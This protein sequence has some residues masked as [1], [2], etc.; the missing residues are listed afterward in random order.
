MPPHLSRLSGSPRYRGPLLLIGLIAAAALLPRLLAL[1]GI[2]HTWHFDFG[3]GPAHVTGLDKL[4]KLS[5]LSPEQVAHLS[6]LGVALE[7]SPNRSDGIYQVA[8][9]FSRHLGP[10]S[11]WTTQLTNG[12]FTLVLLLGVV[13][14]G[15]VIGSLRLGLW[16]ALLTALCPALVGA[17]WYLNLDYPLVAMTTVGVYLLLLTRGLTHR[18]YC[19]LLA[20]WSALALAIKYSYVI[21]LGPM[22]LVILVVAMWRGGA[23]LRVLVHGVLMVVVAQGLSMYLTGITPGQYW[24]VLKLHTMSDMLANVDVVEPLSWQWFLAVPAFVASGFPFPLLLL[25]VPG[26]VLL[27]RRRPRP[28]GP[29]VLAQLWGSWVLLTIIS[30][31]LERYTFPLLPLFCLLTVWWIMELVPRR[32]QTGALAAISVAYLATLVAA[33]EHPPPW[34]WDNRFA[35]MRMPSRAELDGLRKNQLHPLCKMQPLLADIQELSRMQG[36]GR[37]LWLGPMWDDTLEP[38][39]PPPYVNVATLASQVVRDKIVVDLENITPRTPVPPALVVVHSQG[40]KPGSVAP[41]LRLTER[42]TRPITCVGG[43]ITV[44]ISSYR[45]DPAPGAAPPALAR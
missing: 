3:D 38:P 28:W 41:C 36:A 12:L 19:A 1:Q 11:I 26:V 32:W 14:I 4:V 42:R 39:R 18:G 37:V 24:I 25:A 21:F 33:H 5:K 35:D 15:R 22:G 20:L 27:H 34:I 45:C 23:R 7:T 30:H 40:M 31:K 6:G 17:S 13:G 2:S 10:L 9:I 44:V 29:L 8:S 16:A 43:E